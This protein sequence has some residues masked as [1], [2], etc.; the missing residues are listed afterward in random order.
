[1]IANNETSEDRLSLPQDRLHEHGHHS[2]IETVA[3]TTTRSRSVQMS[4]D[5]DRRAQSLQRQES[6]SLDTTRGIVSLTRNTIRQYVPRTLSDSLPFVSDEPHFEPVYY[7]HICFCHQPYSQGYALTNCGHYFCHDCLKGYWT[8][9]VTA[10]GKVF[11]KCFHPVNHANN[12]D[13][14]GNDQD[15]AEEEEK[16]NVIV[17]ISDDIES[18]TLNNGNL[19]DQQ[20]S[21]E[22]ANDDCM[23]G[24]EI[25][26]TDVMNILD[27]EVFEKY[28]RYK[29]NIRNPHARQ[30]P[31][32]D[33]TQS[34]TPENPILICVNQDCGR[35]FC[36]FHSNAHDMNE[37][38]ESYEA[39][40]RKEDRLNRSAV[41]EDAKPCPQC[42]YLTEK[43]SGCNH[44]KCPYCQTNWCY[45]C[46][47]VVDD[48]VLPEHY[49]D[50]D[51][52]CFKRQFEGS[53][54]Q[55]W[56]V[57]GLTLFTFLIGL[58]MLVFAFVIG[59]IFYP[60]AYLFQCCLPSELAQLE[61]PNIAA[62]ERQVVMMQTGVM[63]I[64]TGRLGTMET[65]EM[66][67]RRLQGKWIAPR[68]ADVVIVWWILLM[69][70][71]TI[72]LVV[73]PGCIIYSIYQFIC[74]CIEGCCFNNQR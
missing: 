59:I 53:E 22:M 42:H 61:G 12:H 9:L 32:C 38:C 7:C 71:A 63:D 48:S 44:M 6:V 43:S 36:Y 54:P 58:P 11:F 70:F 65:E 40:K 33:T 1:M 23:C 55:T 28:L 45:L 46:G 73:V 66:A 18:P 4:A 30:C 52:P 29:E 64:E 25:A 56:L 31:Y 15:D 41:A 60:I 14:D 5:Y 2:R 62:N 27:E 49:R 24:I 69:L 10:Q 37:S 74:G 47:Q 68:L 50:P 57:I 8:S 21:A 16:K 20:S 34:G 72:F 39:R 3:T 35:S 19:L 17:A 67:Q 51:S 26:E 13:A